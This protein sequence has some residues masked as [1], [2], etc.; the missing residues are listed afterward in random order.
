MASN[1]TRTE[2]RA[3]A[4]DMAIESSVMELVVG[5]RG[6]GPKKLRI[7]RVIFRTE[8]GKMFSGPRISKALRAELERLAADKPWL[9]DGKRHR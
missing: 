5:R 6:R 3:I 1:R 9:P 2:W 8:S 7:A 4:L